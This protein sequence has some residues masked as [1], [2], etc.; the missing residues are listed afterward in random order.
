MIA[1][2][3]PH[4]LSLELVKIPA[5]S[6]CMGSLEGDSAAGDNEMP[7]HR[8]EITREFFLG[9]FEI[10]Q[11][12]WNAVMGTNPSHFKD[13]PQCPV[14]MISWRDATTFVAKLN[15]RQRK[16]RFRL[17]TE[18]EWEYATR[19]GSQANFA[20]GDTLSSTQANFDGNFPFGNVAQGRFLKRTAEVGGYPPNQWGLYDI[21]GNVWEWCSDY[22][23]QYRNRVQRDP[24]GP[25]TGRSHV[26]RGGSWFVNAVNARSATR[27]NLAADQRNPNNGMRIAAEK[28]P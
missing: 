24:K 20:Y 12:Q 10:T 16:Y 15:A 23:G 5:G 28:R 11:A 14:E 21:H 7:R 8:V 3:L 13:C 17:P 18:A 4:G 26:L 19:A 9:R 27:H 25:A 1:V 2:A 6:F 22:F